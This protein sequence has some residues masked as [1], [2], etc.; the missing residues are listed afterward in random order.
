[1]RNEKA[2]LAIDPVN[3]AILVLQFTAHVDCHVPQVTNH[4][5]YLA[6]VIL[7]LV[8]ARVICDF[9]DVSALWSKPVALIHHA[10]RLVIHNFA[11]VVALPRALV[12]FET[13]PSAKLITPSIALTTY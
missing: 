8:F 5:V 10:L 6:H 13:C 3:L 1:M 12:L 7:H 11:V 4:G 9:G 2:H